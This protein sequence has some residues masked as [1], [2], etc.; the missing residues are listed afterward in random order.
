MILTS[1]SFSPSIPTVSL[2]L[3]KQPGIKSFPSTKNPLHFSGDAFQIFKALNPD[4]PLR[5]IFATTVWQKGDKT[6]NVA[7]MVAFFCRIRQSDGYPGYGSVETLAKSFP[8]LDTVK[9]E[10]AFKSLHQ[11]GYLGNDNNSYWLRPEGLEIIKKL[12]PD[13]N[14]PSGFELYT[15]SLLKKKK[16]LWD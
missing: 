7:E 16:S 6:I 8:G 10:G 4:I 13:I 14:L 1:L 3:Q 15:K 2:G 9:L 12:Y 5:E 11:K